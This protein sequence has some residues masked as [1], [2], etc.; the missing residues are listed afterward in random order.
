[1]VRQH[2]RTTQTDDESALRGDSTTVRAVT[3]S[4]LVGRSA[5]LETIDAALA[6]LQNGRGAAIHL[7]G[8]PGIGKSALLGHA[9][10]QAGDSCDVRVAS[11]D[12]SDQRRRFVCVTQFFP[13]VALDRSTDPIGA[14]LTSIDERSDGAP[15]DRGKYLEARPVGPLHVVREQHQRRA[16]IRERPTWAGSRQRSIVTGVESRSNR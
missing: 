10:R 13:G 8:E 14:V 1:M 15:S 16:P 3:P 5:Q 6:D 12:D 9:L 7:V 4:P 2:R 11:A